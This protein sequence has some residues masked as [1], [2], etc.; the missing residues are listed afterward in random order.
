[1]SQ[2]GKKPF[3]QECFTGKFRKKRGGFLGL[4]YAD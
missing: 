1:M 4:D 2:K 3:V